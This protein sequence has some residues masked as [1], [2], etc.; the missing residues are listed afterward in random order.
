MLKEDKESIIYPEKKPK[1]VFWCFF[2]P[3]P[4]CGLNSRLEMVEKTAN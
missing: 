4:N 2:P 1:K 3:T